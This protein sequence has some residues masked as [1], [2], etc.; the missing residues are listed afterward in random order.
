MS[1]CEVGK[2]S[3]SWS[4][5]GDLPTCQMREL[6]LF[7]RKN[8]CSRVQIATCQRAFRRILMKLT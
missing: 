7:M 1:L 5:V 8:D 2:S 4:Q 3:S 6:I